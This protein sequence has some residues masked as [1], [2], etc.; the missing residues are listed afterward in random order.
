MCRS[1]DTHDLL[2]EQESRLSQ[3]LTTHESSIQELV[4]DVHGLHDK[5]EASAEHIVKRVDEVSKD[6]GTE[7]QRLEA[8]ISELSGSLDG[9]IAD[10]TSRVDSRLAQ[11][12]ERHEADRNE[13]KDG[14]ARTQ[15]DLSESIEALERSCVEKVDGLS[16]DVDAKMT[17]LR[18]STDASAEQLRKQIGSAIDALSS[19]L[20]T[21]MD[22][23]NTKT[24]RATQRLDAQLGAS[25]LEVRESAHRF[26][27]CSRKAPV[28]TCTKRIYCTCI[29][30]SLSL[31]WMERLHTST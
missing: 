20:R 16:L 5:L 29:A 17:G 11:T 18:S 22:L 19:K 15:Q 12:A 25:K 2:A 1:Q 4:D 31:P 24:N 27:E 23:L 14:L 8:Q 9:G 3:Q 21:D 6:L 13:L 10:V 7:A 26:C 28:C 30:S